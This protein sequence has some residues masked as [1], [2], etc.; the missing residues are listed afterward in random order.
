MINVE[1]KLNLP[2]SSTCPTFPYVGSFILATSRAIWQLIAYISLSNPH[3]LAPSR[4][5]TVAHAVPNPALAYAIGKSCAPTN[6]PD[7]RPLVYRRIAQCSAQVFK[8]AG[9]QFS[10]R[11]FSAQ[12]SMIKKALTTVIS[13]FYQH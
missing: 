12:C 3:A 9:R 4:S 5:H 11:A 10:K 2:S 7:Q 8:R 13:I 6:A 1:L